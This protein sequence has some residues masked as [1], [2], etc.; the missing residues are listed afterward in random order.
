MLSENISPKKVTGDAIRKELYS[1]GAH[2]P[3]KYSRYAYFNS[4]ADYIKDI[5]LVSTRNKKDDKNYE[6]CY[7]L[8]NKVIVK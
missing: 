3:C 8:V 2:N 7:D 6:N 5:V 1:I 4:T